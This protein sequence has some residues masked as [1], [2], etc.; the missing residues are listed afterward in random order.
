MSPTSPVLAEKISEI[1]LN[2]TFSRYLQ[3]VKRSETAQAVRATEPQTATPESLCFVSTPDQLEMAL[4]GQASIL[5]AS[6]KLSVPIDSLQAHQALFTTAAMSAAMA[7]ILPL[8]DKKEAR[9]SPGIHPTAVVDPT[10]KLGQDVRIGPFVV[11]GAQVQIGD[12]CFIGSH[13][14][15]EVGATIGARTIL[16][17]HVVIG[18]HC[19]IGKF[20]EIHPH[21]T[22]GSDGFGF[23]QGHDQRRHKIPQLGIVVIEDFVEMGSNCTV[24]RATLGETRIGEGSKFD[25]LCHIGHNNRIGKHNV[26][27]AGFMIAGSSEIGDNCTVGGATVITDHVKIGNNVMLGGLSGVTKDITEAGAYTGYPLEPIKE[28]LK[29]IASLPQI[30]I[31]R[32]QMAQVRKHLGLKEEST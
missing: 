6:D 15:V 16:H 28:G 32:K 23:V 1:S 3:I 13:T 12:Q 11:V 14:V 27:A 21:A 20:C 29:T 22:I 17:P 2:P 4:K 18:A 31:L 5:I 7:L 26:F 10:A 24:D 19:Q 9:F 25:N 8:F 30:K